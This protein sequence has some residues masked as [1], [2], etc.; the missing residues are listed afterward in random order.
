VFIEEGQ[1]T[2]AKSVLENIPFGHIRHGYRE[3]I[4]LFVSFFKLTIAE[5]L[6]E[7]VEELQVQFQL[8]RSKISYPIFTDAYFENY[9]HTEI[10]D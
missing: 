3:F 4:E 8:Y 7:P 5:R 2:K 10:G 1:F 6:E 9:F